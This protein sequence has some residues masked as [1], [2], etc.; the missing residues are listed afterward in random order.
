MTLCTINQLYDEIIH[1][2]RTNN[3]K[4]IKLARL[5]SEMEKKFN[6]PMIRNDEWEKNNKAVISVYRKISLSRA[7]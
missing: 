4:S 3:Q 2:N 6:I 1:S 7:F 5:M